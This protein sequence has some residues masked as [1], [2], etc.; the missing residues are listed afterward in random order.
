MINQ[1]IHFIEQKCK[2]IIYIVIYD[3]KE[4]ILLY[5]ALL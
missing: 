3:S 5:I 2:L 4:N 1:L